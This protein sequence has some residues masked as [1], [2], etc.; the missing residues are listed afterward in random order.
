MIELK[1]TFICVL[2]LTVSALLASA[3]DI[4][5]TIMQQAFIYDNVYDFSEGLAAVKKDGKIGFIDTDGREVIPCMYEMRGEG[6]IEYINKTRDYEFSEGLVA[7]KL[8]GKWGYIDRENNMVV[9]AIYDYALPFYNGYAVVIRAKKCG[10]IN[11]LGEE[12]V[13]CNYGGITNFHE[14]LAIVNESD[15]K[16][17]KIGFSDTTGQIVIPC[18]YDRFL[19]IS[20][21]VFIGRRG[22][23]FTDMEY[24]T[25][26]DGLAA[27]RRDKK[28][29][30]I[31]K[32]GKEIIECKYDLTGYSDFSEG[33]TEVLYKGKAGYIRPRRQ[34]SDS[35]TV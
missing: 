21:H 26:K 10:I 11:R 24:F 32:T 35:P 2:A 13:P 6:G 12:V 5:E 22:G 20:Q 31:D 25:F 18:I 9:D 16:G 1:R 14:G 30:Y 15:W 23:Y 29:G 17:G 3:Q 33:L 28:M 34:R 7:V 4:D 19:S 8:G 27:V